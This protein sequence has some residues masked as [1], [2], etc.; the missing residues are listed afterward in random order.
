MARKKKKSLAEIRESAAK[1]EKPVPAVQVKST[2]STRLFTNAKS[3]T[4]AQTLDASA[5]TKEN[6]DTRPSKRQKIDSPTDLTEPSFLSPEANNEQDD[7]NHDGSAATST[8][9]HLL[10]QG[11][12][13]LQS[14]YR[15]I[16]MSVL[17]SSK[18]EQK[19]RNLLLQTKEPEGAEE[20][21][22]ARVVVLIAKGPTMSKLIS[23]VEIAKRAIVV[24]GGKWFQVCYL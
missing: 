4:A 19:V 3:A 10:P 16:A 8:V 5:T 22:K 12:E 13:H 7:D 21:S 23:I 17:S 6:T 9:K 1:S 15:F 18:I 14:Q 11:L 2:S 20:R 24:E